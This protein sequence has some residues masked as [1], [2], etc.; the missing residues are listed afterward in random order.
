MQRFKS[1]LSTV[2]LAAACA[3]AAGCMSYEA[4][5]GDAGPEPIASGT[6]TVAVAAGEARY[7]LQRE[8]GTYVR[9]NLDAMREATPSGAEPPIDWRTASGSPVEVFGREND[10]GSIDVDVMRPP[11]GISELTS[12]L[13]TT[14]TKRVLA[15]R[16]Q[17]DGGQTLGTEQDVRN[18]LASA[19]THLAGSSFGKMQ[20][21]Y[22]V[23]GPFNIRFGRCDDYD[24]W[25]NEARAAARNAGFDLGEYQHFMIFGRIDCGYGG[26][27]AQPG[28]ATWIAGLWP[29][30]VVH[31][32]G[33]NFGLWHASSRTCRSGGATVTMSNDCTFD[34]YGDP[35]DPMGHGGRQHFNANYK[36][37]LGWITSSQIVM[38]QGNQTYTLAPMTESSG[39]TQLLRVQGPNGVMYHVE[40]RQPSP[41]NVVD[42][43]NRS[44]NGVLVHAFFSQARDSGRA[45]LLDMIPG[46]NFTDAPLTV[47]ASHQFF[48]TD[49]TMKL[50][51]ISPTGAQIQV[52]GPGGDAGGGGSGGGDAGGG[53]SGGDGSGGGDAGDG[54]GGGERLKAAHS[55]KCVGVA[56][57]SRD[58]GATIGQW[59]CTG[60][61]DQQ[62]SIESAGGS[63]YV[64]KNVNSGKCLEV[65]NASRAEKARITQR[66]CLDRN[67]QKWN[68]LDRG[69]GTVSLRAVHSGMCMD[70]SGA[71]TADGGQF[72]QY[73]CHSGTNQRFWRQ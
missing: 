44:V 68:L 66:D 61:V 54:S 16:V 27:G 8:D 63:A 56:G 70:I 19:A 37:N 62:W 53:G 7:M 58:N 49:L 22:D 67:H 42:S 5:D 72:I 73:R 51:S 57:A 52:S 26:M 30:V 6:L 18:T 39:G 59:Q 35:F 2:A 40:F 60:A 41:T 38:A 36:A 12:A 17:F 43:R 34:E 10:D 15:L 47:G 48:G 25:Q 24:R 33:H 46:G 4:G 23:A 65:A 29:E 20:L 3:I 9:L 32:L 21:E 14:G 71:S 11:E 64:V 69:D 1:Q 55:G 45:H 13:V 50:L 31:E 28:N